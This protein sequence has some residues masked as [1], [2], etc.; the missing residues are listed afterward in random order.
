MKTKLGTITNYPEDLF[1]ETGREVVNKEDSDKSYKVYICRLCHD[2]I[3]HYNWPGSLYDTF[4]SHLDFYHKKTN[5]PN[6]VSKKI[7]CKYKFICKKCKEE[8]EKYHIYSHDNL[9]KN[10]EE[11][12][13]K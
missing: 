5:N 12:C 4:N 9:H 10:L 6:Y 1:N 8:V 2:E 11:L 3:K 13:I 7:D